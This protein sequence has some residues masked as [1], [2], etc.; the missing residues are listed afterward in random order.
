VYSIAFM[1]AI[2][3]RWWGDVEGFLLPLLLRIYMAVV[4]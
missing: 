3:K 2:G 1:A 4:C